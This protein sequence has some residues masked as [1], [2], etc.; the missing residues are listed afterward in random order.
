MRF[1][2]YFGENMKKNILTLLS[3]SIISTPMLQANSLTK[4]G[5]LSNSVGKTKYDLIYWPTA[6]NDDRNY[7]LLEAGDRNNTAAFAIAKYSMDENQYGLQISNEIDLLHSS[8]SEISSILD[9]FLD[10]QSSNIDANAIL[11]SVEKPVSLYYAN[12]EWGLGVTIAGYKSETTNDG[13]PSTKADKESSQLSLTGSYRMAQKGLEIG[14]RLNLIGEL[15]NSIDNGTTK[16]SYT[17]NTAVTK[18]L[19]FS[20]RNLDDSQYYY[21]IFFSNRTPELESSNGTTTTTTKFKEQVLYANYNYFL[22]KTDT[23]KVT[24]G[25]KFN[26]LNSSQDTD[27][28]KVERNAYFLAI[29]AGIELKLTESLGAMGSIPYVLWGRVT[30]KTDTQKSEVSVPQT[31]DPELIRLG[32]YYEDQHIRIDMEVGKRIF[33]A[34]PYF[35]SGDDRNGESLVGRIAL[36][37]TL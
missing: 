15:K 1:E 31:T 35:I 24:V 5:I 18:D 12:K 37:Y 7:I 33:H 26:Y 32:A 8:R 29:N 11:P 27:G 6:M 20:M 30:D 3:L 36:T 13:P 17:L 22:V 14:A 19:L 25:G 4:S 16:T 34:G 23:S 28:T 9:D 21:R 10:T 2:L